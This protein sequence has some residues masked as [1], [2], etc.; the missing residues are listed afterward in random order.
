M[1]YSNTTDFFVPLN[2][3]SIMSGEIK[4]PF[5]LDEEYNLVSVNDINREHRYDHQYTCPQCGQP[6]LPRLGEKRTKHFYHS[7][8]QSCGVE[9]YVHKI[10]KLILEQRFN[11]REIPFV[12]KFKSTIRCERTCRLFRLSSCSTQEDKAI[13]LLKEYDLPADVEP[14]VPSAEGLFKP[15]VCLRSSNPIN[16]ELFIEVWYK[17][18]SSEK[19]IQSGYPIIEFHILSEKDLLAL[20]TQLSFSEGENIRFY[21]FDQ[22]APQQIFKDRNAT[23]AILDADEWSIPQRQAQQEEAESTNDSSSDSSE[24]NVIIEKQEPSRPKLCHEC[25]NYGT[26]YDGAEWCKLDLNISS[27]K[28]TF[29]DSRAERCDWYKYDRNHLL[30]KKTQ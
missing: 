13:D 11:N 3:W 27:R 19:K 12:V 29:D 10:A 23:C 21:N 22:T 5:A 1:Y 4:Y 26:W 2:N 30:S 6:M 7:E 24:E 9:S 20:S 15:D 8:N 17:H 25:Q 28:D 14:I 16:K 18:P